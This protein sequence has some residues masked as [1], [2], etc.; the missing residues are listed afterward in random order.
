[1][2]ITQAFILAA[3]RGERMKPLTN[4][5]PKPLAPIKGKKMI[6]YIVEKVSIIPDINKII[7]NSY[8]LADILESHIKSLNNP[9]I[10]ISSENE[11]LETGGGLVNAL[12]LIDASKP[13]LV[14]NGDLFWEDRCNSLLEAMIKNF[15]PSVMDILLALKLKEQFIG[16][17]GGGDFNLNKEN[18]ELTMVNNSDHSHAYIGVQIL[19]PRILK[20]I[21]K[22]KCFSISNYFFN[23]ISKENGILSGIK[24]IEIK[25]RVF[26]IGTIKALE[27]VNLNPNPSLKS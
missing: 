25:E 20:N 3:G 26:H 15:D 23:K 8:Y 17:E 18:G 11:K 19:H 24:G 1:M 7:I 5:I 21:S 22:E 16:Y 14:I 13:I 4:D 12:A 10:I 2:T 6:D 27:V 9:K